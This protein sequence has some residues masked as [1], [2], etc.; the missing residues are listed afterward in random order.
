MDEELVIPT[1]C[2]CIGSS[3]EFPWWPTPYPT[4]EPATFHHEILKMWPRTS[5]SGR[6]FWHLP[7]LSR[8]YSQSSD[9]A[10][11]NKDFFCLSCMSINLANSA[12]F[13]FQLAVNL[14]PV[15]PPLQESFREVLIRSYMVFY[16]E[17]KFV[18][19]K[20]TTHDVDV[21][22]IWVYRF[23]FPQ[24]NLHH[25]AVEWLLTR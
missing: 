11:L 1:N 5:R 2:S 6:E 14:G 10:N 15:P 21:P 25:M 8:P 22:Q 20:V 24:W 17:A 7:S 3:T 23:V 4:S 16:I 19:I 12:N 18:E 9:S 13:E